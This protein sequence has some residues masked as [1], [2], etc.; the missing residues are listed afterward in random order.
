VKV[1]Q[2]QV[3]CKTVA[4]ALKDSF[5]SEDVTYTYAQLNN[6]IDS[7]LDIEDQPEIIIALIDDEMKELKSAVTI[8]DDTLNVIKDDE[9]KIVKVILSDEDKL[10]YSEMQTTSTIQK[11][12]VNA[13][14]KGFGDATI[15]LHRFS[16]ELRKAQQKKA[17]GDGKITNFFQKVKHPYNST[18]V[19]QITTLC[20]DFPCS[21]AACGP[22]LGLLLL[23]VITWI[24]TSPQW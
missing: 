1:K 6:M 17:T 13:E 14:S 12:V 23:L 7:W 20:C 9:P 11:L 10:S 15:L 4:I 2:S 8:T 16:A 21:I 5:A 19:A 22:W 24:W 18:E 3:N